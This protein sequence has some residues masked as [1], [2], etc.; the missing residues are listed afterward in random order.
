MEDGEGPVEEDVLDSLD[1]LDGFYLDFD[2]TDDLHLLLFQESSTVADPSPKRPFAS[3]E[4]TSP[5]T[6]SEIERFLMEDGADVREVEEALPDSF[7]ADVF[8]SGSDDGSAESAVS[9]GDDATPPENA[10]EEKSE[11]DAEPDVSAAASGAGF[12]RQMNGEYS[13]SK[14]DEDEDS[15]S[16]KRRRQ[17]RNRDSAMKSRERKK[18]YVKDLEMK[19]KFMASEVRRLQ[20]ALH[21]CA[22]ENMALRQSLTKAKALSV[23]L[24]IQE[25]A[26]L[27]VESLLLGSLYWLVSIVCLFLPPWAPP[28]AS[29]AT[30]SQERTI[31]TEGLGSEKRST[32]S[33]SRF[34]SDRRRC[35]ALKTKMKES[36]SSVD[37][38]FG[39]QLVSFFQYS[40]SSLF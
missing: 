39:H 9:S 4:S 24:A 35:R 37:Q 8:L 18:I 29:G 20:H 13:E 31:R 30:R 7:F 14:G 21:C 22:A 26:V 38:V 28:E 16:K 34:I 40:R 5:Q 6:I 27:F 19:S 15:L 32:G 25:S 10:L 23:P 17:M 3:G 36:C 2:G 33:E 1:V 12:E 11:E